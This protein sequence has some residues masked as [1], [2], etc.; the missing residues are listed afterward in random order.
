M[1]RNGKCSMA[2][3]LALAILF[4]TLGAST[5]ASAESDSLGASAACE[6]HTLGT[7]SGVPACVN[8]NGE[9]HICE[10]NFPDEGF[11][12]CVDER[13]ETVGGYLTE[14]ACQYIMQM[15][16][17]GEVFNIDGIE[18]FINLL[19]LTFRC[20]TLTELDLT[21]NPALESL[22]C[23]NGRLKK[24][25]LSGNSALREVD[26]SF[27]NLTELKLDQTYALR[28]LDCSDNQ[29]TRLD[30]SDTPVLKV[31][32][33]SYNQLTELKVNCTP[34]LRELHCYKNQLQKLDVSNNPA[35]ELLAC[36]DNQLT[37]LDVSNNVALERLSCYNNG[38]KDLDISR[39]LA[40]R[41]LI[42]SGNQLTELDLKNNI[43][44][45]NLSCEG[46]QLTQL[47]LSNIKKLAFRDFSNQHVDLPLTYIG[48]SWT[49]NFGQI[50]SPDNFD[51]VADISAGEWDPQTGIVTFDTKPDS[52]TYYYSTGN[53]DYPLMDVT[54]SLL[55]EKPSYQ[56]TINGETY[57]YT[58]TP[59]QEIPLTTAPA[60]TERGWGYRFA[61]WSGDTDVIAD[62]NS[63]TTTIT[64]PE[65]DIVIDAEYLLIG[66][67]NQDGGLTLEDALYV[68]QMA[69]GNRTEIAAGDI[70]G[71]GLISVLD[72]TYM[73]WYLAGNY[74]PTK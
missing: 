31:L 35:M 52:F 1:R 13:A 66:D 38:L 25:D 57:T 12:R 71:D 74:I 22:E 49:V 54:V 4:G 7:F 69:A 55:E 2:V 44:L 21:G 24:I 47:E 19:E 45:T 43:A 59:G 28:E 14:E 15:Q 41:S 5:V 27:N 40:L 23:A 33:C 39:N 53:A 65:R 30:L 70:D 11:R 48:N 58:Y 62:A 34:A 72:I 61:G 56:A 51:R 67:A 64:M 10:N 46:N 18:Y 50:L 9:L 6:G 20:N 8:E 73:R 37:E 29:L 26:C 32:D 42:C 3:L 60:Y 63:S 16:V 36:F 68:S 17:S